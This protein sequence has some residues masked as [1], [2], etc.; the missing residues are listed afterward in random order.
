MVGAGGNITRGHWA[1][2]AA[3]VVACAAATVSVPVQ[4]K[5]PSAA[6]HASRPGQGTAPDLDLT[7]ARGLERLRQV[8]GSASPDRSR[9]A[10]E[11]AKAYLR[12]PLTANSVSFADAATATT[13]PSQVH[14]D[15]TDG[16]TG[17]LDGDG[18]ADFITKVHHSDQCVDRWYARSG[19]DGHVLWSLPLTFPYR[20]CPLVLDTLGMNP[21]P[22]TG[23]SARD[24]ILVHADYAA[25]PNAV[26]VSVVDAA[27]GKTAW[28]YQVAAPVAAASLVVPTNVSLVPGRAG[29]GAVDVFVGTATIL[30]SNS[31]RNAVGEGTFLDGATGTA[32]AHFQS[33]EQGGLGL[34]LP[35][36]LPLEGADRLTGGTAVLTASDIG[37]AAT[38]QVGTTSFTGGSLV[39]LTAHSLATGAVTWVA[40]H[41]IAG[42]QNSDP[43]AAIVFALALH[44]DSQWDPVLWTIDGYHPTAPQF[45]AWYGVDGTHEWAYAMPDSGG[46]VGWVGVGHS[47][48]FAYNDGSSWHLARVDGVTGENKW[49]VDVSP[50]DPEHAVG[51][52][53]DDLAGDGGYD[54]YVERLSSTGSEFA[55]WA[56]RFDTGRTLWTS[57]EI[58][59]LLGADLLDS[60]E[61]SLAG[62]PSL[63]ANDRIWSMPLYDGATDSGTHE[64]RLPAEC[65]LEWEIGPGARFVSRTSGQLLFRCTRE[66]LLVDRRGT[67][68]SLDDSAMWA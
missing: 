43:V 51:F 33:V 14:V 53:I 62:V 36:V 17:D 8:L 46:L 28:T 22:I 45:D 1:V 59:T 3:V 60:G 56:Y 24:L 41:Q 54:V 66:L 11:L 29:T 34:L 12:L 9:A 38:A 10:V 30:P 39:V 58:L 19:S 49:S 63:E 15:V 27:T 31:G 25:Q 35:Q 7:K 20:G 21:R 44:S 32:Y 64:L 52:L 13:S 2:R 18:Y 65:Q 26:S 4:A 48:L 16:A 68:W 42:N 23:P 57:S 5:V 40:Q 50:V 61:H 47:L 6:A 37:I 55:N 67:V